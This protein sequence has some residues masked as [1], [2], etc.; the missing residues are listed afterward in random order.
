MWAQSIWLRLREE[1]LLLF[2]VVTQLPSPLLLSAGLTLKGSGSTHEHTHTLGVL[3][4]SFRAASH[5]CSLEMLL[6]ELL[7]FDLT[8]ALSS[9]LLFLCYL[10]ESAAFDG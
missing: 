4:F 9:L 1:V 8:L 7:T 2:P 3:P 6:A 10:L 5:Y